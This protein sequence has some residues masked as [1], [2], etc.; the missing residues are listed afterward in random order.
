MAFQT[1]EVTFRGIDQLLLNNP[2]TAD[3]LNKYSK[4]MKRFTNKRAKVDDDILEMRRIEMRSKIYWDED[5]G[6]YVPASWVISLICGNSWVRCKIKKSD[7]R[8]AVFVTDWKLPLEYDGKKGVKDPLDIVDDEKFQLLKSL[9]QGRDR[10][11]KAIPSF[12][13]WSFSA[14]VEYEDDIISK[15][16]IVSLIEYGA[17]FGGLGD[18]RPTYGRA[19]PEVNH[20]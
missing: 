8:A 20:V 9:K 1:L 12:E 6:I 5:M 19:I 13:S 11:V 4:E 10:I 2:Q 17:K 7:I 14:T 15:E 16:D 3:P 18:F